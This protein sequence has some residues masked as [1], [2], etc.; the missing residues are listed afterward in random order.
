MIQPV[1]LALALL[2]ARASQESAWSAAGARYGFAIERP[3]E[4]W[5][6]TTAEDVG[7]ADYVLSLFPRGTQGLP[8]AV[9][10]VNDA[11]AVTAEQ[12]LEAGAAKLRAQGAREIERGEARVAKETAPCLS[13]L[14]DTALGPAAVQYVFHVEHDVLYTLQLARAPDDDAGRRLLED[15]LRS[16]AFREPEREA[17]DP[18]RAVWRELAA[19]CAADLGWCASWEEASTRAR[20]QGQLVLVVVQNYAA[21]GIPS[22]LR[23]GPFV[24]PDFAAL[25][26]ERF[27]PLEL[28]S[29]L[30]A[31]FRDP[32]IYGLG[33]HAWGTAFLFVDAQGR[34]LDE[35]GISNASVLDEFARG[36]LA[37]HATDVATEESAE[38]ALARGELARA[39][40]L[41]KDESSAGA[42]RV[43][44]T[45]AR[46]QRDG[47]T[48]LAELRAARKHAD[49]ALEPELAADEAL[50]LLRTRET[51][52][53]RRALERLVERWPA[54]ARAAEARFYLGALDVQFL[55]VEAGGKRW[56][57]LVELH[58]ETPWAAKAAA[59]L[60]GAGHFVGGAER[61]D[62]P[63]PELLAE[64]APLERGTG[65]PELAEVR[66][67]CVDWL[68]AHQKDD[69][70]WWVPM[71][72]FSLASTLYT[73]AVSAISA[74]SLVPEAKD[75]KARAAVERTLDHLLEQHSGGRL[76][77]SASLAGVYSIWS[78]T[79]VLRL[80]LVA[81]ASGLGEKARLVSASKAL[82]RSIAASQ[83]R[84]GGW[85]YVMLPGDPQAE[86][87][88]PSASF[89][90]AGVLLVLADAREAGIEVD[91]D[92]LARGFA[93]L[94]RV[95]EP[96]GTFRYMPDLP[97]R[98]TDGRALEAFGRGPVCAFALL[99]AKKAELASVRDALALFLDGRAQ[100]RAEWHKTLCHTAQNGFGAHYL[101][102]DYLFAAHA[103]RALP[104]EEQGPVRAAL[105]EDLLAERF[106]DGS[107]E[108]LPGLGRAYGTAL[109]LE[110]LRLCER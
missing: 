53:A 66:R 46:R 95:R 79:Y 19:R 41:V 73:P 108:D 102:F 84:R 82:V 74:A 51:T 86:G 5:I 65:S 71:D 11:P 34:V 69:G 49:D 14:M 32:A 104:P 72:G 103:M 21:L 15:V 83:D 30:E 98:A 100:Y 7:G 22:T 42:R 6:W 1:C 75:A 8:S 96:D 18:E 33:Q 70:S 45:V 62:W 23:S 91:D 10:Y 13:A 2:G 43:R 67:A 44:A 107:F 20:E 9:L 63:E 57:E 3:H 89:L 99:R 61:L 4:D 109:A 80:F 54:H 78:R 90:T 37:R 48:A 38:R 76:D 29:G 40:E 52:D 88:E 77:A 17:E 35:C 93:F 110:T 85:P 26:R 106:E 47:K 55:G 94:E 39:L 64:V 12:A 97:N 92:V 105:V 31:P 28:T 25:V 50:V 36:V 56:R 81:R 87:L 59:N 68:L 58:P 27:V 24:D 101:F 16:L 60:L